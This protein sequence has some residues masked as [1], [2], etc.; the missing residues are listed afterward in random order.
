VT[1]ANASVPPTRATLGRL[2]R[3]LDVFR[4]WLGVSR[5][6]L[7]AFFTCVLL[8]LYA[9]WGHRYPVG[10]D[11]PQ[12]ANLFRLWTEISSGPA[13]YRQLYRVELFTPYLLPYA[14][15]YVPT[16]LFDALVATKFLLTISAVLSP[17][18]LARWLKVVGGAPAFGLVGLV[19]AFDYSYLWGFI[20]YTCAIPLMLAYFTA[21]KMQGDAPTLRRIALV[22]ALAIGLFFSHGI[23]F[24]FCMCVVGIELLLA[25]RW[26]KRW[27]RGLHLVPVAAIA[28]A[29]LL[30]RRKQASNLP[31]QEWFNVER[32][33]TLFS[34][35]FTPMP[36]RD[37]ALV[38]MT[39]V[40]AFLL[41]AR[42]RLSFTLSGSVPVAVALVAFVVIPDWIASTWL[43][44]S[45]CA[46]FVHAFAPALLAP[47]GDDRISKHWRGVLFGL[48][49]AFLLLLNSRLGEFNRELAGLTELQAKIPAG[50]D[51][52][53]LVVVTELD[54]K[55]FGSQQLGQAPAWVTATQGGMIENDSA[56]N[57]YYQIPIKR[58]DDFPPPQD[59]RFAIAHGDVGRYGSM[60]RSMTGAR[61]PTKRAGKWLLYERPRIE[62]RDYRVV[63][64]G[65]TY[66]KLRKD[67]AVGGSALTIAGVRYQTG[68]GTHARSFVRLKFQR[69]NT[70]LQGACGLDDAAN[71][72]GRA[73]FRIQDDDDRILF[74]SGELTRG[75]AAKTFSVKVPES[76][77]LFFEVL[78]VGSIDFDHADWV[79]LEL[80]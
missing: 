52:Q 63:R 30:S 37:W 53:T 70:T 45:R 16:L 34:S 43:V 15:A 74:D 55:A 72:P 6:T 32:A 66:G 49:A 80:R 33:I 48:V 47:A 75:Q 5:L 27:R 26:L 51:V 7:L 10:I 1:T 29:W 50:S 9:I 12:H 73:R 59:F 60:L 58:N 44:G 39:G 24:G 17:F 8:A 71:G 2:E 11:L 40:L 25:G 68:L 64:W 42:P 19:V 14:L 76:G 28:V 18:L 31:I 61:E 62:G 69:A 67:T 56:T 4:E 78:P 57:L 54:S 35:S 13:E 20:S 21:V 79:D 3:G 36:D 41:L 65:Q 46:V 22:A 23:V 77:E 38:A